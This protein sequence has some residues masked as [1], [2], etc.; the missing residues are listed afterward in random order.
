MHIL[1]QFFWNNVPQN[2]HHLEVVNH[3]DSHNYLKMQQRQTV[4]C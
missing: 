2:D 1:V 3:G 4:H